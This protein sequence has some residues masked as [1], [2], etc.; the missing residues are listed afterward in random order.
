M[1]R[2]RA[3]EDPRQIFVIHIP[4]TAGTSLREWLRGAVGAEALYWPGPGR[5]SFAELG[6]DEIRHLRVIG[7]HIPFAEAHWGLAWRRRRPLRPLTALTRP[8]RIYAAVMREPVAAL[9][10]HFEHVNRL[11]GHGWAT[12]GTL[13][14]ALE[15]DVKFVRRSRNLQCH[16]LSGWRRARPTLAR[17]QRTPFVVG[18]LD[19]LD[20]FLEVLGGLLGAS[21]PLPE[22]NRAPTT[23]PP[24]P[25]E[26]AA[27]LD[28]LTAEDRAVYE[29]VRARGV[30]VNLDGQKH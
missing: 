18:T 27:R 30:W 26:L 16:Y 24:L 13:A 10:S 4:R 3:A 8:P 9:V 22:L 19:R 20:A 21:G 28:A 17:L 14:E 12:G 7:G 6:G 2:A 23:P 5:P 1:E 15:R 29:A 11:P 25:P